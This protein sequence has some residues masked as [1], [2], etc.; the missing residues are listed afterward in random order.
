V[1]PKWESLKDWEEYVENTD[2]KNDFIKKLAVLIA[3]EYHIL[4]KEELLLY[5]IKRAS[6]N[7]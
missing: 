3:N 5:I 2:F 4:I 7:E 1:P 6:E